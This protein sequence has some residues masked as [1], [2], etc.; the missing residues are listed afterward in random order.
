MPSE[1]RARA[2]KHGGSVVATIPHNFAIAMDIHP[3][4]WLIV[5]Y[6]GIVEIEKAPEEA[7]KAELPSG[8]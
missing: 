8:R 5:R 4:T 2:M 7:A 3:G 1:R 6:N